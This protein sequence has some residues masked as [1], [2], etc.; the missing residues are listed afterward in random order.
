MPAPKGNKNA[1]KHGLYAN[2]FHDHELKRIEALPVKDIDGEIGYLRTVISRIALI[3][4]KNGLGYRSTQPLSR[5]S[6]FSSIGLG[7]TSTSPPAS[8]GSPSCDPTPIISGGGSSRVA[9]SMTSRDRSDLEIST[10]NT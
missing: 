4:E 5:C 7:T 10:N 3:L 8:P 2:R 1:L 9:S 6:S